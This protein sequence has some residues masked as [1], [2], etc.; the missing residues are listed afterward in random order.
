MQISSNFG[1]GERNFLRKK[2]FRTCKVKYYYFWF[3]FYINVGRHCILCTF[4]ISVKTN[5]RHNTPVGFEPMTFAILE[6]LRQYTWSMATLLA[7]LLK[8]NVLFWSD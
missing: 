6:Q 2:R 4:P 5:Y 1:L 7:T 3:Y 8:D